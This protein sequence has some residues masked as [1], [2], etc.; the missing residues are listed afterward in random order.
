MHAGSQEVGRGDGDKAAL[1]GGWSLPASPKQAR[2][3]V[4]VAIQSPPL[5]MDS[6][7]L[8]TQNKVILE[9]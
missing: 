3:A 2:E 1:R 6:S 5:I 4:T 9:S 8:C 7:T